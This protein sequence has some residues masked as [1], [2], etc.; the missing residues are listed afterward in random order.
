MF[1]EECVENTDEMKKLLC[2][3]DLAIMPSRAEG[4]GLVA[5]EALSAG[6]PVLVG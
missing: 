4:F 6:L 1:V 2:E 5:L 3:V